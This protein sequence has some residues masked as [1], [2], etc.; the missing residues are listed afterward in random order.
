MRAPLIRR[1]VSASWYYVV[2]V[3][4]VYCGMYLFV[5][6]RFAAAFGLFL[7]ILLK[8]IPVF[9][10]VFALMVLSNYYVSSEFILKHFERKGAR[11]WLYAIIG[12]MLATGPAYVWYPLVAD[13]RK[14]GLAGGLA[15]CF[16]YNWAVKLPLLPVAFY[17][18][19]ISFMILLMAVMII[20]SVVQGIILNTIIE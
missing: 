13:L 20:M 17:Y 2:A 12:G 3:F 5:P 9:V 18:F 14:K 6:E 19:G 1:S 7:Q 15:A 10:F 16:L 4:L 8:M 11:R